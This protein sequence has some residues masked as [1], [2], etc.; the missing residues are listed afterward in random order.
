MIDIP[1]RSD[2]ISMVIVDNYIQ[3]SNHLVVYYSSN[4]Q[5]YLTR[6][7]SGRHGHLGKAEKTDQSNIILR[8]VDNFKIDWLNP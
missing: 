1:N 2:A 5:C 6:H 4:V 8:E 3:Y 7:S